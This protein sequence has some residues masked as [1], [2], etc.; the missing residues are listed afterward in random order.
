MEQ[1]KNAGYVITYSIQ[2]PRFE[3]VLGEKPGGYVTWYCK[4]GKEYYFGHYMTDPDVA[5]LDLYERVQDNIMCDIEYLKEK[6]AKKQ[7]L[8]ADTEEN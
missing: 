1:R 3:Y 5:L 6:I 8:S 2:C 4:N 7:G